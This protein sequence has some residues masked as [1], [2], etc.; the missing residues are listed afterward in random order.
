MQKKIWIAFAVAV[1]ALG[2]S[3]NTAASDK[4]D[5]MKSVTQFV[6]AFN[7]GDTKTAAAACADQTA[8][9]DEFP[10]HEWHGSGACSTWMNDYD[11]DA[12]KNGITDGHVTLAKPR[13]VDVNGDHAYVV[14]PDNYRFKQKGKAVNETG[15]ILTVVLQKSGAEWKITGWS[16]TKN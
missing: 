2:A 7:K 8:I 11:S 6:D 1:L 13:H 12:K 15:S 4:S 9:I 10:P 3:A 16:W 5:V 14:V